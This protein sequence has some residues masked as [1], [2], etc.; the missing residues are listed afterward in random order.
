M[1][2]KHSTNWLRAQLLYN[3]NKG[4]SNVN[5]CYTVLL[6]EM[7]GK[8]SIHIH[9]KYAFSHNIFSARLTV[10]RLKNLGLRRAN[11]TYKTIQQRRQA[12]DVYIVS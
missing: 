8:E 3:T 9:Y 11:Y 7:T 6:E 12:T 2:S 4:K 1:L 10:R 5:H